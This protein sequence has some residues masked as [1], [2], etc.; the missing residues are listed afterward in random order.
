MC[1]CACAIRSFNQTTIRFIVCKMSMK[2]WQKPICFENALQPTYSDSFYYLTE[3]CVCLH[4]D[5]VVV[6]AALRPKIC[7]VKQSKWIDAIVNGD[8][9]REFCVLNDNGPIVMCGIVEMS[10]RVNERL[11]RDQERKE[12]NNGDRERIRNLCLCV[13]A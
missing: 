8:A 11:N 1:V 7:T 12:R 3:A 6:A 2:G 9:H 5:V 13:C 4:G 10:E